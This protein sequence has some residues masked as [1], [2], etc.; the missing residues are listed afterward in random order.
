MV[1][2]IC[3]HSLCGDR[4]KVSENLGATEVAPVAPVDTSLALLSSHLIAEDTLVATFG[5][6]LL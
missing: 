2:R 1:G 4:V 3:P 5:R 6:K